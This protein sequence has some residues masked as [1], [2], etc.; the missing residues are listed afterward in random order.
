MGGTL[1]LIYQD[2]I[3]GESSMGIGIDSGSCGAIS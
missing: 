2:A 1:K 3:A